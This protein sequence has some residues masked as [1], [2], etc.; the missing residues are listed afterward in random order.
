METDIRKV[1]LNLNNIT[2]KII[3]GPQGDI[4]RLIERFNR[5]YGADISCTRTFRW[6]PGIYDKMRELLTRHFLGWDVKTSNMYTLFN[7]IE[8]NQYYKRRL[9]Q[10]ITEIDTKLHEKRSEGLVFQENKEEIKEYLLIFLNKLSEFVDYEHNGI[11]IDIAM[12]ADSI[13]GFNSGY[14]R[15]LTINIDI[16]IDPDTLKVGIWDNDKGDVRHIAHLYTPYRLYLS[17]KISFVKWFNAYC[18]SI[19]KNRDITNFNNIIAY[20][21]NWGE[22]VENTQRTWLKFP[23][24]AIHHR[25]RAVCLG[26]LQAELYGY[27]LNLNPITFYDILFRWATTFVVNKSHPYNSISQ[28]FHGHPSNISD[29]DLLILQGSTDPS[30]CQYGMKVMEYLSDDYEPDGEVLDLKNPYCDAIECKLREACLIYKESICGDMRPKRTVQLEPNQR[31][32]PWPSWMEMDDAGVWRDTRLT[33]DMQ[34]ESEMVVNDNI[35]VIDEDGGEREDRDG[36]S[37]EGGFEEFL[38]VNQDIIETGPSVDESDDIEA[39]F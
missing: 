17:Y 30:N 4:L 38:R 33:S 14:N 16:F 27:M 11:K 2:D 22:K 18:V 23:Y 28:A 32:S 36:E 31:T 9:R 26:E 8:N 7:K 29:D 37:D 15:D 10:S 24:I 12:D 6:S 19:Q 20:N 39:P 13:E 3:M 5:A 35:T 34:V 1:N 21:D 25:S